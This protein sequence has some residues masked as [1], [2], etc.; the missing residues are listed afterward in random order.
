LRSGPRTKQAL[1]GLVLVAGVTALCRG[2]PQWCGSALANNDDPAAAQ[3]EGRYIQWPAL[4]DPDGYS[5]AADTQGRWLAVCSRATGRLR[6]WELSPEVT[7]GNL[8]MDSHGQGYVARELLWAGKYL[9]FW[10]IEGIEDYQEFESNPPENASEFVTDHSRTV[11]WDP[12]TEDRWVVA[13]ARA[14]QLLTSQTGDRIAVFTTTGEPGALSARVYSVPELNV[15]RSFVVHLDDSYQR[16]LL[17]PLKVLSWHPDGDRFLALAQAEGRPRRIPPGHED[18]YI[19]LVVLNSE[20]SVER[21]SNATD[22]RLWPEGNWAMA[23]PPTAVA[24][25]GK[26]TPTPVQ[27]GKLVACIVGPWGR[28]APRL[29]F[30]GLGGVAVEYALGFRWYDGPKPLRREGVVFVNVTVTPDGRRMILQEVAEER[31]HEYGEKSRVWAWDFEE[32]RGQ[33]LALVPRITTVFG[34][35]RQHYLLIGTEGT[36]EGTA[37][38]R[39]TTNDYGVL[40][41]PPAEDEGE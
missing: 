40:Y 24:G 6:V 26:L 32:Q 16:F 12:E 5:V 29:A 8:R 20:G 37:P 3:P 4:R 11:C 30:F 17:E 21:L 27:D 28:L 25:I 36:V 7:L 14:P 10:Q 35:T 23:T 33:C 39:W 31:D 19:V 15:A 22:A 34:W 9:A 2:C 41:V 18:S 1:A 38:L 13:R